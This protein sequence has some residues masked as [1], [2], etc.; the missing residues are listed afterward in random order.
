MF[1][2]LRIHA[3]WRKPRT[4]YPR[5]TYD[6]QQN[7]QTNT[8]QRS[9]RCGLPGSQRITIC[10]M[11]AASARALGPAYFLAC[12]EKRAVQEPRAGVPCARRLALTSRCRRAQ[13]GCEVESR[14][15]V[16]DRP[17]LS[18]DFSHFR[19]GL[20]R[21]TD[22]PRAARRDFFGSETPSDRP[23]SAQT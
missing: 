23:T 19:L 17:T 14:L 16:P 6:T 4:A 21:P 10:A 22:P 5:G 8:H 3:T 7:T 18:Y 15:G 9:L 1:L 11:A 20:P 13:R 12:N 2:R